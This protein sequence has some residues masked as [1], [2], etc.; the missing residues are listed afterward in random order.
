MRPARPLLLSGTL[1]LAATL[2][3]GPLPG[4]STQPARAADINALRGTVAG[5]NQRLGRLQGTL[6]PLEAR[7]AAVQGRLD[8]VRADLLA[9]RQQHAEAEIRLTQLQAALDS[10]QQVLGRQLVASYESAPPDVVTVVLE[11]HGFADL[12]ERVDFIKRVARHNTDVTQRVKQER[13]SVIGLA[14]RL[15]QLQTRQERDARVVFA[16]R[17]ALA[18]IHVRLL[19]RKIALERTRN[20]AASQLHRLEAQRAAYA[21]AAARAAGGAVAPTA[22]GPVQ[23]MSGGGFTFPLPAG[24]A[25]GP[26]SWSEDQGVDISAPGNTPLLAGGSGTIVLH[27]IGGFGPS[28]PVLHLDDGRFVYYGHAGPGNMVAVG[29]HVSAGQVISEVGAGIVG[30]STGP[31]LEIGFSD[32]SGTPVPSTS[33][34]MHALLLSAYHG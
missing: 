27:G 5:A 25:V 31:H 33:S 17:Q 23:A 15:G 4:R 6:D 14:I 3:L 2:A 8:T 7:L 30:I 34:T 28:A 20:R 10:D 26:G 11:A 21:R 19:D 9:T 18:V 22:A 24:A 29:T 1:A 13:Q 12:I 16:E 32:A